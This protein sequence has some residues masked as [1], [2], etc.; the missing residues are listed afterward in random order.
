MLGRQQTIE[1]LSQLDWGAGF[2]RES[3]FRALLAHN[4][5]LPNEFL[6]AIPA[7]RTFGDPEELVSS[8]PDVVWTIHQEREE[9]AVGHLEIS[10]AAQRTRQVQVQ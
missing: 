6:S 3:L 7:L 5:A 10:E 1:R 4:L 8:V 9:R 2:D